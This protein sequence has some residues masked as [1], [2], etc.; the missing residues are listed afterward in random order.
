LKENYDEIAMK[1]VTLDKNYNDVSAKL[2]KLDQ[3]KQQAVM[4]LEMKLRIAEMNFVKD[5]EQNSRDGYDPD[6]ILQM[7]QEYLS[8]L[9]TLIKNKFSSIEE[10]LIMQEKSE[11][12]FRTNLI[13]QI[14]KKI[15]DMVAN[16]KETHERIV[17]EE[18]NIFKK[19]LEDASN[20]NMTAN[21]T[22][23]WYKDQIKELAPYKHKYNQG[24]NQIAKLTND[25]NRAIQTNAICEEKNKYLN[26]Y[27]NMQNEKMNNM[28][29]AKEIF[30]NSFYE[31]EK[32]FKANV[33]NKNLR[34]LI[35]FKEN[36]VDPS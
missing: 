11:C 31:S 10:K 2:N 17:N 16:F 13:N 28:R 14:E 34:E 20:R 3:E 30:K 21:K 7:T 22:A 25:L 23:E 1:N 5:G 4:D 15:N 26:D 27:I 35:N 12:E 33:K 19:Q 18:K 8:E 32:L 29:T 9:V 24:D 6:K 36:F